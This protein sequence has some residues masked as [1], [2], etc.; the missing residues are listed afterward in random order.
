M[1]RLKFTFLKKIISF[2]LCWVGFLRYSEQGLLLHHAQALGV[3]ASAVG[4]KA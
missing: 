4:L 2:R 1:L 3:R